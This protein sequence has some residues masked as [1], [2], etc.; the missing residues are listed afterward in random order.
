[1]EKDSFLER[2]KSQFEW[3]QH[4]DLVLRILGALGVGTFFRAILMTYTHLN[5]IWITPIWLFMS[6]ILIAL[7]IWLIP[8]WYLPLL[9]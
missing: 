1:M 5:P 2:A 8:R 4:G 6:A 9:R 3:L 7:S